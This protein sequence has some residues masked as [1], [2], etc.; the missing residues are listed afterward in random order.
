MLVVLVVGDVVLVT[1][2]GSVWVGAVVL[3]ILCAV[4][5][6]VGC[7]C[8]ST[9]LAGRTRGCSRRLLATVVAATAVP[10]AAAVPIATVVVLRRVVLEV[11]VL[12]SNVGEKVFAK[13]LGSLDIIGIWATEEGLVK[14]V[15][16]ILKG[17]TY[18]TC[19]N[20]GSSL[21]RPVLDSM[22]PELRPL[23]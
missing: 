22:K 6:C 21:S 4:V 11:L 2:I 17:V 20:M 19:R 12:L 7:R 3:G 10:I 15:D 13:L 16:R 8:A 1:A 5:S 14:S 18:A 23:I 9:T